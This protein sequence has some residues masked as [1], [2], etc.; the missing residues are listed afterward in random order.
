MKNILLR[1]LKVVVPLGIGVWLVF[2][3]Y[4]DL[5]ATQKDELFAAFRQADMRWLVLATIVGWLAHVSR[6]WR[7]RYLLSPLGHRPSFWNCYHAVMIGYFMNM[8]IQRAGEASRAVSLY[9]SEKVPF[10]KGFGTV[11]AERVVDT[12]MLA[13]IGIVTILLQVDKIDLFKTR[14]AQYR[15][16]QDPTQTGGFPWFT[17]ILVA[18][19]LAGIASIYLVITRPALRARAMDVL[20]GFGEGLRAVL[21]TKQKGAFILHTIF[22]WTAY[23]AMFEMGFYCLP[24]TVDVPFGGILAGFIAGAIGIVLVQG[25]IGVYPA[26]V[27]LTVGM[28]MPSSP[29]GELLRPDALAMGWLLWAAQTILVVVLGGVSLLLAGHARQNA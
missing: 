2:S 10:E 4:N 7:W 9:R 25:G 29:G 5:S 19:G 23:L 1:V 28:Y 26:L 13:G 27:A 24:T 11:L 8:F 20:R 12:A 3:T 15:A 22:I 16:S 17:V 21:R 6:G 18:I 14:I